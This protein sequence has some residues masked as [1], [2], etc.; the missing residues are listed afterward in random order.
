MVQPRRAS[1]WLLVC[2]L[3]CLFVL[4]TASSRL[5]DRCSRSAAERDSLP[6]PRLQTPRESGKAPTILRPMPCPP[7]PVLLATAASATGDEDRSVE[8]T[9]GERL[10]AGAAVLLVPTPAGDVAMGAATEGQAVTQTSSDVH[11]H[12][13]PAHCNE[14]ALSDGKCNGG[15]LDGGRSDFDGTLQ[16]TSENTFKTFPEGVL[17]TPAEKVGTQVVTATAQPKPL[18]AENQP[19]PA[20][21]PP[22]PRL[23]VSVANIPSPV[24]ATPHEDVQPPKNS[25]APNQSPTVPKPPVVPHQHP[26]RTADDTWRDPETLL[27]GLGSLAAAGPTKKWASDVT[28]EIRAL[29]L[30]VTS[31]SDESVAILERLAELDCQA[32]PLAAKIADKTLARKLKKIGY[33]LGRRIDVWQEIVRL[34]VPQPIDSVTPEVEPQKLALCLAQVDSL[35]GN[36]PEGRQWRDYLLL[37]ALTQTSRQRPSWDDRVSRETARQVLARLTQTPLTPT[38]QKFVTAG[39]VAALRE[40]LR[41]WA[42]E[43]IGASALLH[44]IESYE[45]SALPSDAHR[46]AVDYQSLALSPVASR[47]Q[48]ADRVDLHY[49]NAN[50]RIA[51]TEE[52]INKLIPERPVEYADVDD[53]VM[54]YPV[55]GESAIRTEVAVRMLPDPARVRMALEVRGAIGAATTVDAGPAQFRNRSESYYVARKPLE[56]DMTGVSVWPVEVGVENQTRL[57]GVS[58]PLDGIPVLGAAG[59]WVAKSQSEQSRSAAAEEV[60]QKIADQARGRVDAEA[61]GR[62]TEFV[63]RM[64]E[65]VFDPLNALSLDPQMIAGETTEKRFTMRL[66]LAGEDQLGS[67]TPRP[68]AP[69]DALASVQVH[70]SVLNN[71]IERLQLNGRTFTLPE[72]SKHVAMRLNRPAPWEINPE[73]ADVKITFA[74]KDAVIV[75]CQDGQLV[76]KMLVVQLSKAARKWKNFQI[77]AYYR[78]KVDGRSAELV[79]EG[80]IHLSGPRISTA[81]R[82]ALSGIFSRALSKNNSWDLVP[83]QIVKEPKL[84]ETAITQFVI[85]DGWIGVSLGPKP[86]A[87]ATARRA[88]WGLW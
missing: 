12:E 8:K 73:H 76:L 63:A 4:S 39:P 11:P 28:G 2:V 82:I 33:A 83:P 71:A 77:Q 68:Q 41:R 53:T 29:K 88:R 49:R 55:R 69:A 31:G 20:S 84:G 65:K 5:W 34:G 23:P 35:V 10:P 60:K 56:I 64:N 86:P 38:Q 61:R 85:D 25:P 14:R 50:L 74:D 45:R 6:A 21:S 13:P 80:V 30:A 87:A 36:S 44:D 72:L 52:L 67:H 32:S 70:E 18:A 48:L 66:R 42:V 58:T 57:S 59:R 43:P 81:T 47:R 1:A 22:Q 27:E 7:P 15:T 17:V 16:R 51:V 62:L 75:R 40:E 78:P 37:D 79:R 46:L 54:G 3:A 9:F 26:A 19:L 24:R